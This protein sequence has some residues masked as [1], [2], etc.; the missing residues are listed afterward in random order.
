M[1]DWWIGR[2]AVVVVVVVVVV[3]AVDCVALGKRRRA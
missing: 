3:V 2:A 1:V